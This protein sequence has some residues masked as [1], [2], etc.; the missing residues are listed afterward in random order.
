[1]KQVNQPIH[2]LHRDGIALQATLNAGLTHINF[3][4]YSLPKLTRKK[5]K[6]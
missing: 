6:L 5:Q 3:N 1:M 2:Q 4:L